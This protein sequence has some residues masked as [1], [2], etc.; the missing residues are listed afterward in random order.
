M[1]FTS[2]TIALGLTDQQFRADF[3]EFADQ[4]LYPKSAFTYWATVATLML[5]QQRW[6]GILLLAMELFIAHNLVLEAQAQQTA[7]AGG[8]PGI[9]KGAITAE[10]PGEVSV[11]YDA[12]I[13]AEADGGNWNLTVYGTRFIYW[14]RMAGSGGAQIGPGGSCGDAGIV[15]G[16]NDAVGAAW[17]GPNCLPGFTSFAS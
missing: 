9:S 4:K 8:W 7:L 12:V 11:S 2:I 5:N 17:S 16:V 6:G 15:P 14:A 10:T 3:P 13:A 1:P